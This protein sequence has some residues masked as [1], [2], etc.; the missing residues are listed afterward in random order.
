MGH[1]QPDA[2][3]TAG[4][5]RRRDLGAKHSPTLAH[6]PRSSAPEHPRYREDCQLGVVDA[7]L[8]RRPWARRSVEVCRH[9]RRNRVQEAG[10]VLQPVQENV[11]LGGALEQALAD[12][13]VEQGACCCRQSSHW[14]KKPAKRQKSAKMSAAP[15]PESDS[16]PRRRL[17][18][19]S[20]CVAVKARG[21]QKTQAFPRQPPSP[22]GGW[23]FLAHSAGQECP[24][25]PETVVAR[26][27]QTSPRQWSCRP[28]SREA[29][30]LRC[31]R[32]H[33]MWLH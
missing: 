18:G 16:S 22:T 30:A 14:P 1:L 7:R 10:F 8:P 11:R 25:S 6:Q 33:L 31:L 23:V 3:R 27:V 15:G 28:G 5:Q 13:L 26:V 2:N 19:F 20:A 12:L 17:S 9:H 29:H 32:P 24:S 21:H 4:N